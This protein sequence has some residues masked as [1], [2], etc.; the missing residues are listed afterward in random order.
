MQKQNDENGLW[1]NYWQ[2]RQ[3]SLL[4]PRGKRRAIT[5]AFQLLKEL[6]RGTGHPIRIIELGC[7]EGHILGEL[8]KLCTANKIAIKECVGV[9]YQSSAIEN[10][11]R[12]Y[13]QINFLVADYASQPLSLEPFDMVMLVGTLHEVYSSN[14]SIELGEI[15]NTLGKK[16]V[17]KALC[18]AV[19][20][21]KDNSHMVLFDGVEHSL[22]PDFKVTVRFQSIA[23]L[24]EFRKLANEYEAFRIDYEEL[25]PDDRIRISIHNFTRYITKT[26]FFNS[27]LWEIEKRESY[28][29][30]SKNEFKKCLGELGVNILKL[31][32]SS[33]YLK[34]WQKRVRIETSRVNFPKENILIVGQRK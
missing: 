31:Q 32:C 16:A 5:F 12:L 21:V 28:Q 4:N 34:D 26:R 6:A 24:N 3:K 11:R 23:A 27:N 18:H 13:P 17:K 33:P 29:Y 30:F 20:L 14:Y 8:L 9:D 19:N 25:K 22:T 15:D 10:A 1:E 7:G 2:Q